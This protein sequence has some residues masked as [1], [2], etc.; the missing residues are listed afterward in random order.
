MYLL[1]TANNLYYKKK[2]TDM[3]NKKNSGKCV[4]GCKQGVS[5]IEESDAKI[6]FHI[7]KSAVVLILNV[8]GVPIYMTII[9]IKKMNLKKY[10]KVLEKL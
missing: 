7:M 4:S 6:I 10:I 1:Y 2:Y 5:V 3:L 8:K 9:Y